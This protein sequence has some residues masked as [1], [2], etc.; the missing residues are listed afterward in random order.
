MKVFAT[1]RQQKKFTIL[2]ADTDNDVTGTFNVPSVHKT[3]HADIVDKS[4]GLK[5][6]A[7]SLPPHV[8]GICN[9]P[10]LLQYIY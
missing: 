4:W 3:L 2:C 7:V 1:H 9:F 6:K 8:Q 10:N 5:H